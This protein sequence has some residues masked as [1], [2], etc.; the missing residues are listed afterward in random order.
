MNSDVRKVLVEREVLSIFAVI[1]DW[2]VGAI[3]SWYS[4]KLEG[5]VLQHNRKFR[6]IRIS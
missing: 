4:V 5:G 3:V 1:I 6:L 2:C